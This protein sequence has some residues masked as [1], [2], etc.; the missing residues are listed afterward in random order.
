MSDVFDYRF[1]VVQNDKAKTNR[2]LGDDENIF[3]LF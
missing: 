1:V 3:Q 2:V